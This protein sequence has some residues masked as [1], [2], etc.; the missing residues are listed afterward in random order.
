MIEEITKKCLTFGV[1]N[2]PLIDCDEED[3]NCYA[4]HIRWGNLSEK[5]FVKVDRTGLTFD[6]WGAFSVE[7]RDRFDEMRGKKNFDFAEVSR[8]CYV[9][10]CRFLSSRDKFFKYSADRERN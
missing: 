5:F 4:K 8:S 6:P 3:P 7:K 10:Y 9:F 1:E 2:G